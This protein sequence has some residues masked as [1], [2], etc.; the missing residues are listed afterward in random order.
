M[1]IENTETLNVIAEDAGDRVEKSEG[2]W[3]QIR[4]GFLYYVKISF[5]TLL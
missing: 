3:G 4:K 5:F 1:C 2:S